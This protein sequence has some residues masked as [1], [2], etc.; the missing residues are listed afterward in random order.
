MINEAASLKK[1][2]KEIVAHYHHC[3]LGIGC[4]TQLPVDYSAGS[5]MDW[6]L[7]EIS[8]LE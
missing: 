7:G 4:D 5:F 3:L 1:K 8:A 2:A 6:L